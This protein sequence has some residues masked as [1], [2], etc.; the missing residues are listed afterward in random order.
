MEVIPREVSAWGSQ[1]DQVKRY[2]R[3]K[4]DTSAYFLITII[5]SKSTV[6]W[7]SKH[8]HSGNTF[9]RGKL[10]FFLAVRRKYR[11]FPTGILIKSFHFERFPVPGR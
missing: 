10:P 8:N 2:A 6:N 4:N 11:T 5:S 7:V 3:K 9:A 1:L